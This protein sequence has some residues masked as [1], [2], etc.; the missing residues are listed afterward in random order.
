MGI[1]CC[2]PIF[3]NHDRIF[4]KNIFYNLLYVICMCGIMYLSIIFIFSNAYN[5]FI[6]LFQ[7]LRGHHERK[8]NNDRILFRDFW[9]IHFNII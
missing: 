3:K 2:F 6:Y 9:Y 1:L 8:N 5:P 4:K 7:F